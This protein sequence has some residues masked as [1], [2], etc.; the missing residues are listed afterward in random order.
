MRERCLHRRILLGLSMVGSVLA[1]GCGP[2]VHSAFRPTDR[3]FTPR[4]G[5]TPR[6]YLYS[7]EVPT[8]RMRTV[9]VVA[10]SVPARKGVE[11]VIDAAAS[12]GREVGC[13]ALVEESLFARLASRAAMSDPRAA[14]VLVHQSSW[15]M[16]QKVFIPPPRDRS[17][18]AAHFECVFRH[19]GPTQVQLRSSRRHG[20]LAAR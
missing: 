6:V 5:Q 14:V 11:G 13:W 16:S 15:F 19:D 20:T 10:V 9:G 1:S 18:V 12:K 7:A 4:R 17:V 8:V 2:G 3:T